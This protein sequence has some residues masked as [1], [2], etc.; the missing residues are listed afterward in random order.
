MPLYGYSARD[1]KSKLMH[2]FSEARNKEEL[3]RSLQAKGLLVISMEEKKASITVPKKRVKM[4]KKARI[5]DL[6]L[7]ARQISVLLESGVTILKAINVVKQQIQSEAL[8]KACK[9]IEEELK[10]GVSLRDALARDPAIFSAI[11]VDLIETGEATGQLSFV[12]QKLADYFEEMNSLRKKV[13]SALFYPAVLVLVAVSAVMIF[14]YKVI[15]VFADIYKGM[16][17]LPLL[18]SVLISISAGFSKYCVRMVIALIIFAW[19]FKRFVKTPVGRKWFDGFKLRFPVM[20]GLFLS[21]AIE[22]F[23]TCLGMMLKGGISIVHALEIATKSVG[24]V[25]VEEALEKVKLSI[26]QG[27]TISV[28]LA[29]TGIF[30]PMVSQMINVGE[31]S[32]KLSQLLDEVSRYYA[33][34]ISNKITRL[35]SL[36][37]PI[38]LVVMGCVIGTLVIAMY[39]PIFTMATST[40]LR[41]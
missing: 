1:Q 15:P 21:I 20:G 9:K 13:I 12:L 16:G 18:T 10:S 39:L 41:S 38:L 28:P 14:M 25:V 32:G 29:E 6:I 7:F 23:T 37:E 22:R 31:E 40:G 4:H 34:D 27:K 19:V 30:P 8:F 33:D 5:E 24:N 17:K 11:W 3:V 35:I 36:F 2:G 26:I